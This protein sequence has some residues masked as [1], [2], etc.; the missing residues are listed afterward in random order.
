MKTFFSQNKGCTSYLINIFLISVIFFATFFVYVHN[1]SRGVYGGDAGDFLSAIAVRGIPHPSGYPLFTLL[2]ILASYL[3]IHQTFAFKVSLISAFATTL[4]VVSIY[5]FISKLLNKLLAI[6]ASLSYAFVFPIWLSAEYSEVFALHY[7]LLILQFSCGYLLYKKNKPIYLYALALSVG[8]AF[9]N[10]LLSLLLTPA[11]LF[12]IYKAYKNSGANVFNGK[13]ISLAFLFFLLGLS[14]YLYIPIVASNNP[15]VNSMGTP[16]LENFITLVTRANYGWGG[17]QWSSFTI[18]FMDRLYSLKRYFL[19]W[20]TAF[21]PLFFLD[22]LGIINLSRKKQYTLLSALILAYVF[23]GLIINFYYAPQEI[24]PG[25]LGTN[26]R[27]WALSAPFMIL[28]LPFGI[29]YMSGI[30]SRITKQHLVSLGLQSIFLIMPFVLFINNFP[31]TN[32]SDISLGEKLAVDTLSPLPKDSYV[33]TNEDNFLFNGNY[34]KH[35]QGFRKDVFIGIYRQFSDV[36]QLLSF[37]NKNSTSDVFTAPGTYIK[38]HWDTV[39]II[40]YGLVYKFA[41]KQDARISKEEYIKQQ[42]SLLSKL[43]Q[44][45]PPS[46]KHKD[47]LFIAGIP[48]NYAAAYINTGLYLIQRYNDYE[49]AGQYFTRAIEMY[50]QA[51]SAYMGLALYYFNRN[52]CPKA[53]ENIAILKKYGVTDPE[54]KAYMNNASEFINTIEL[55]CAKRSRF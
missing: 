28:L 12:F 50:P 21:P 34:M 11:L 54:V 4:A 18:T 24:N 9:S 36:N 16:S 49:T 48:K 14:P 15:P 33:L 17:E 19:Y 46:E 37:L 45:L 6:I 1:L 20:L 35:V 7:F 41:T 22:L 51:T 30:L 2:G 47:L 43:S 40:P 32:L 25:A 26:E 55:Q 10:N 53:Q 27:Y 52:D 5:C 23:N 42:G 31:K 29:D 39:P 13:N 38:W 3:P 8:L 44:D